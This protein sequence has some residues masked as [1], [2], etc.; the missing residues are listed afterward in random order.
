MKV[1]LKG[2]TGALVVG[3]IIVATIV[4]SNQGDKSKT[5]VLTQS[6]LKPKVVTLAQTQ[7]KG[8]VR[9]DID[10]KRYTGYVLEIKD[11]KRIK[12]GYSSNL[13]QAG[14]TTS[15]IAKTYKAVAAINGGGFT[16]KGPG[17]PKGILMSE[18]KL[19]RDDSKNEKISIM[20]ITAEG[21]L[22]VGKHNVEEL[23]SLSVND[24]ISFEPTIIDN[25]VGQ[26]VGDGGSGVNPRTAIGQKKDGTMILLVID[27]RQ[28]LKVGATLKEVQ[29][30]MLEHAAWRA[31]NLDGGSS[32]TM[33]YNGAL[34]NKP[35]GA[36]GE[37]LVS[38]VV[39]VT[40]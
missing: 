22:M 28:G 10:N 31:T 6:E 35:C 9:Y 8:I 34:V 7:D 26:I 40:P 20:G 29:D 23:S 25:G 14:E 17:F 39:Y 38:S 2:A 33:Y 18:G 37:R 16:E 36:S 30:I 13:G 32:S 19:V 12:V 11:P 5:V 1:N 24:A 3:A 27:G 4:T 21:K 15:N